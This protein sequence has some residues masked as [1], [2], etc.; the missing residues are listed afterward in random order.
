MCKDSEVL[1]FLCFFL[2]G[3]GFVTFMEPNCVDVVLNS[4]PHDLDGKKVRG[5]VLLCV[6]YERNVRFDVN[7]KNC[8]ELV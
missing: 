8:L 5:F 1:L 2:R 6:F 7:S 4:C 3:F